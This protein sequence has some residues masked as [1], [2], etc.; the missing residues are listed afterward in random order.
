M[1]QYDIRFSELARHTVWLV[2]ADGVRIR[3][4]I[5][6]LTYQLLLL[7]TREK[8]SNATFDEVIDIDRHIEMICSLEREE[9]E[10]KRP[11]GSIGPSDV[12]SGGQSYHS[13]GRP[14]RPAQMTRPAHHSASVSHG[15]YSAHSGQSLSSV[16]PVQSSH[17]A[18]FAQVSIDSFLGYQEQQFRQRRGC[19][20]CGD[21]G[22]IKRDCPRLLSGA[23]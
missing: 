2:P 4:F 19:L 18:S 21:M 5:D 16:L 15:S 8:V 11:R 23:P 12:H 1:T 17:H 13:R 6:G 9:R 3:R 20:E 14:Y 10:A 7:M 22:H